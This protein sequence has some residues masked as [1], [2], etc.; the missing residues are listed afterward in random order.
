MRSQNAF[1]EQG[2]RPSFEAAKQIRGP[3]RIPNTAE[4]K[5]AETIQTRRG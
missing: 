5:S 1:V 2:S 3:L 4:A